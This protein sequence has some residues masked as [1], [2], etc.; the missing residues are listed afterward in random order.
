MQSNLAIRIDHSHRRI[1]INGKFIPPAYFY[2]IGIRAVAS[3]IRS[4]GPILWNA[5]GSRKSDTVLTGIVI[6]RRTYRERRIRT[7]AME[8]AG[9]RNSEINKIHT[10]IGSGPSHEYIVVVS[11]VVG[12]LV[13]IECKLTFVITDILNG[14]LAEQ[15]FNNSVVVDCY[16][17]RA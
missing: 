17:G 11:T 7:K 10:R 3:I 4:Q 12:I 6:L 15:G 5:R 13:L 2:V 9:S 14:T 1:N 8:I 16:F